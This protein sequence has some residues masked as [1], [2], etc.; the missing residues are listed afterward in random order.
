MTTLTTP[1]QAETNVSPIENP[2]KDITKTPA[3][4]QETATVINESPIQNQKPEITTESPIPNNKPEITAVPTVENQK[5]T[6]K[7]KNN[8]NQLEEV[9]KHHEIGDPKKM[10]PSADRPQEQS[11]I[12]NEA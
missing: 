10:A 4:D 1:T 6:E 5:E 9:T 3:A 8:T 12:A 2:K 11:S 7:P